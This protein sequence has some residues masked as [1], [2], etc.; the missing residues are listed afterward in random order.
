[1]PREIGLEEIGHVGELAS[2]QMRR[3]LGQVIPQRGKRV[4]R[5]R[6]EVRDGLIVVQQDMLRVQIEEGN[7]QLVEFS[8]RAERSKRF[9]ES[10]LTLRYVAPSLPRFGSGT[11][12]SAGARASFSR[13]KSAE[14]GPL[15]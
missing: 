7:S 5:R 14:C 10:A 1:M 12:S 2:A 9:P 13:R 3:R 4:G 6:R 8:A 11:T 15:L